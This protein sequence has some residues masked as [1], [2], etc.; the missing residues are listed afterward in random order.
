MFAEVLVYLRVFYEQ[1]GS[2]NSPYKLLVSIVIGV[3]Y[4]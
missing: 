4:L 2:P 3:C 1:K